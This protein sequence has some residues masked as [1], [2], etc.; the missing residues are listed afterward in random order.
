[1]IVKD[2]ETE[3][4]PGWLNVITKVIIREREGPGSQETGRWKQKLERCGHELRNVG[5]P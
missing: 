5:S 4:L 2:F 3:G 1:M